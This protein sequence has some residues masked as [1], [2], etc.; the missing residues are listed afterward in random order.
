MEK[1]RVLLKF[2][3]CLSIDVE[4]RSGG[5]AI[6]W[7]D[8]SKCKII[9]YCRNFINVEVVDSENGVWRLTC[10][11]GFPERGRRKQAW[12]MLRALRNMS[13]HPW[14]IIGDFN[15]LLSQEDKLGNLPHPNW[16]CAGFR[17]AVSDCDLT[18][19]HLEGHRFTWIKS[20]G[21]A[22]VIEE[23]LDRA[24]AS[25][26]WLT[27]FPEVKLTNLLASHSDHSPILLETNRQ[28][29]TTHSYSFKFEN[30]WLKEED[31]VEV[32]ESGWYKDPSAEVTEKVLSCADELQ[33]W[34]RRKRSRFKEEVEACSAEM[35]FL[36]GK[37][38]SSSVRR[39]QELQNNH[40]RYLVQEE[41]YWRQRAK[42]H[43]LREGDLNTKFF[44][45]SANARGKVKKVV[46]LVNEE[47]VMV[48]KQEE[49][50]EVAKQYFDSLFKASH[51]NHVPVLS[52]IQQRV[53]DEDNAR[54]TSP[55]LKEEIYNA[56]MQ[57]HPDKSPGP[58][59]FNPAFYQHF[60]H[61]CGDDIFAAVKTWLD[62]GFFPTSLNE[63]NICLIPKC[64]NPNSM[65]DLRPIALC[66]V[67]YKLVSKL[68]ANRLK[69]CIANCISEEQSAFVEGRSIL[70]NALIAMEV[71]HSLKRRTR[72]SKG[73]LAL[74]ID[75]SKAFD[76][77]DWGFLKG[78]LVRMGFSETWVR[79]IMMC[80]STVNYSVLM[81]FDKVGP[82]HPGRGLRQGDPLSPYL[83]ILATEGLTALIKQS[84]GRGDLHGVKIC[85][86]APVVSHLLFADDCF[87]FCRANIAEATHLMSLLDIYSAASGQ[88]INLSK[89]EVFFSRNL[90]KAAQDD[91]SGIMGVK[92]VL[93]TGTYL[94]LPSMVG[95]SKKSTFGYIKDRIWKKINSWRGRA[96]SKAGKEV[97]I[98]SVLQS[99]P[100][101]IMSVYMIPDSIIN[102]IEKMLNSFW[103][104]DGSNNKGIR[105]LAWDKLATPKVDGGLGFRNFRAFNMA[106]VAKQAWSLMAEPEKLVARIFKARYFPRSTLFDAK[107]GV[108]PSYAWRSIWKARDVII[109]GCRW[110][111]GDGKRISVMS[112]PWLRGQDH[113]WLH[114]PQSQSMYNLC[115]YNLLLQDSKEWDLHKIYSIFPEPVATNIIN[116]PLLAEVHEDKLTWIF[117]KHG[118]YSVRSGYKNYIKMTTSIQPQRV[119]GDWSSIWQIKAPP[120]TKH[121][122]WRV[123]RGCLP[124]RTRLHERHVPC[125]SDCPIC[126]NG[127]EDDLHVFFTC[128]HSQQVWLAAGLRDIITP[129]L[130]AFD[131][132][133]AILFDICKNE[134]DDVAGAVAMIMWCLWNNRNNCVWNG[135]KDT[136]KDVASRAAHMLHDWRAINYLQQHSAQTTTAVLI[137]SSLAPSQQ[138]QAINFELPRWQR[139]RPYWWKCNVDASF[140]QNPSITGWGWCI[141]NSNGSFIAA[142]TN[143]RKHNFTVPEGEALAIL[144]ALR[145]AS[146]RGWSNIIFESDSKVVVDAIKATSHGRSELCSILQEIKALL[147]TNPNFEVKFTK[148]QANM[149]AHTLARAAI[150]W[151]SRTFHNSIPSCIEHFIINEMS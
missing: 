16:L 27:L 45:M 87:L 120:K 5:L 116:T 88:E 149:A 117:E 99:I 19:I 112:D 59:G 98:K 60:W 40:A 70:D 58:D 105:W 82:I 7:N 89:S 146:S 93:G 79:W 29:R 10:Y 77:V 17:N 30:L 42:M 78:M 106:M 56:L 96:L 148:R 130:L 24:M 139:P 137:N 118:C 143:S 57:M 145:V 20:G 36:R 25:T 110:T 90:S 12:D 108:N 15:D 142:G 83:F 123:C 114:A 80:V 119:D 26:E 151:S 46:K 13:P 75:I 9:N 135:I 132:V 138:Q 115:V 47:N 102:D 31:I 62:R 72:G 63:T 107:I 1:I 22:N 91:L 69:G 84:I 50:C 37:Y 121:L 140:T 34:G 86:G 76:K 52:L 11:Y 35:E 97:M 134:L 92:H 51:G 122:L 124:T 39:Y 32:V 8:A 141:R 95:R 53:T 133:K 54:L 113:L 126:S 104:G 44:H 109:T 23:R 71:I 66:N 74:K 129:R 49:L 136:A 81:N 18:D 103:W 67:L 38:D 55:I 144:E 65:K 127:D 41:T 131:N 4:G 85:R 28:T 2:D 33:R 6:F 100:A 128:F 61:L 150:S 14:C 48:T 3:S 43:W 125:P 111:I 101:Y 21:T 94:G 73:E 147:Q 64:D 68:L